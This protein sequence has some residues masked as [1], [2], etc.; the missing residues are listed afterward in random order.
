M[1][2]KGL[3]L[4]LYHLH[5][6]VW[7]AGYCAALLKKRSTSLV[8]P[9]E[10]RKQGGRS[11]QLNAQNVIP[12]LIEMIVLKVLEVFFSLAVMLPYATR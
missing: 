12:A 6:Q 7:A 10:V 1:S 11:S 5:L 4:N 9:V 3:C 2:A 8:E